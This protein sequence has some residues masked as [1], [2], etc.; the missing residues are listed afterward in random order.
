MLKIDLI[1]YFCFICFENY[2]DANEALNNLKDRDIFNC[3]QNIYADFAQKKEERERKLK[4]QYVGFINR[5]NVYI[6][7]LV[8]D[9]TK[10]ALESAFSVFGSK[11]NKNLKYFK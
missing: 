9:V 10:E 3:G 5:T 1:R 6:K 8:K 7:N 2:V 4:E 11:L